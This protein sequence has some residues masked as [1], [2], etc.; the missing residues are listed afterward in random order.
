MNRILQNTAPTISESWYEDGNLVDP[1]VVTIGIA[2]DDGTVVVAAGTATDGTG[3]AARSYD[4]ALA[5]TAALGGLT[6]TWVSPTKG[7]LT[8]RIEVVGG[9]YF[10][11][12]E[13]LAIP[14]LADKTPSE[15]AA[16]RTLA[17]Q[18]FEDA[19]GVAF[20][21]R[22]ERVDVTP[23]R[24]AL[25]GLPKSPVRAI[26]DVTEV[27]SLGGSAVTVPLSAVGYTTDGIYR[28]GGWTVVPHGVTV[29]Y[30]YGRDFPPERVKRAVLLLAKNWLI[31][32]PIDDRA[33]GISAGEAGGVITL[34]TPGIRG[35][36]FGIPEVEAALEQYALIPGVG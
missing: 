18:A 23:T 1:G 36:S 14:D 8:T 29:G 21:P 30:E 32:G 5:N 35:V 9:F 22:Y 31:D 33:T 20:V 24:D 10:T 26:H 19:A 17:E 7:T 25:I 6:A 15:I 4:L 13:A 16:V 3:A 27:T 12:S 11:I 2:R 28:P 34:A